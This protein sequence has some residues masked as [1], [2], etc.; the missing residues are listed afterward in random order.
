MAHLEMQDYCRHWFG[1]F[2]V[3][4]LVR[5]WHTNV[6]H[7]TYCEE[8]TAFP[9]HASLIWRNVDAPL[10]QQDADSSAVCEWQ[11]YRSWSSS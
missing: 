8:S 6:H 11:V 5:M 4:L 1:P 9:M 7:T 10:G 2:P 3:A